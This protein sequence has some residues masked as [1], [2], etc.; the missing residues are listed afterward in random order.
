M[1]RSAAIVGAVREHTSVACPY[2]YGSMLIVGAVGRAFTR[3]PV[4]YLEI[5]YQ[6]LAGLSLSL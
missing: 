6:L 5:Y 1:L 4:N 3:S 2:E